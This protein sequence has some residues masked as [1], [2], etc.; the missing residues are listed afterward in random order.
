M[1]RT[2]TYSIAS[3]EIDWFFCS[4]VR[5]CASIFRLVLFFTFL[6][7]RNI[8]LSCTSNRSKHCKMCVRRIDWVVWTYSIECNVTLSSAI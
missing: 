8:S 7:D 4:F 6:I 2:F 5:G 1:D 3:I